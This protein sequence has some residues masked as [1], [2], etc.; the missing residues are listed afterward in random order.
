M[1]MPMERVISQSFNG[2]TTF[3]FENK[4]SGDHFLFNLSQKNAYISG[5]AKTI[6]KIFEKMVGLRRQAKALACGG[7]QKVK[8]S[9][10]LL[11]IGRLE[12]QIVFCRFIDEVTNRFVT[13]VFPQGFL[14]DG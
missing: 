1:Q 7:I 12:H 6:V 4:L 8:G 9:Q 2:K 5:W 10:A 13:E 3:E 14:S 11:I